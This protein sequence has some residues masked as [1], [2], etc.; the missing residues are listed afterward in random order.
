MK[1]VASVVKSLAKIAD[2]L[3]AVADA[4]YQRGADIKY[5]IQDLNV[6]LMN[7][8]T[9]AATADRIATNIRKLIT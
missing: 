7:C 6:E 2:K 1:T 8:D 4:N 5:E 9:E 3:D